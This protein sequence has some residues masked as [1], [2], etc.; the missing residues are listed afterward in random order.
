MSSAPGSINP[1][2][3]AFG[4]GA[5]AEPGF[6]RDEGDGAVLEEEAGDAGCTGASGSVECRAAVPEPQE[7]LEVLDVGAD[8]DDLVAVIS[9]DL[10]L[11]V[12]AV[13]ACGYSVDFYHVRAVLNSMNKVS[14]FECRMTIFMILL[15]L[16]LIWSAG[17]L[18]D[19]LGDVTVRSQMTVIKLCKKFAYNLIFL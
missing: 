14:V 16:F 3:G 7:L 4:D 10:L 17:A 12:C 15:S 1:A 13:G 5:G 6:F 2:G 18:E 8:V 19:V 9:L 11:D